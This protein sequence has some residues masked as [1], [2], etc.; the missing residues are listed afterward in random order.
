MV[1]PYVVYLLS[2]IYEILLKSINFLVVFKINHISPLNAGISAPFSD[3]ATFR[4]VNFSLINQDY[5][6]GTWDAG[7]GLHQQNQQKQ[8]S[9]LPWYCEQQQGK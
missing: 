8:Q 3:A 2:Y 7:T 9:Y 1:A 5:G 4:M 6:N